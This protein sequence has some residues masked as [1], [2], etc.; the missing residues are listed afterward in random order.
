[1]RRL[2]SVLL[3]RIGFALLDVALDVGAPGWVG[4]NFRRPESVPDRDVR[5]DYVCQ[6]D[7]FRALQRAVV[8]A[9]QALILGIRCRNEGSLAAPT[10][11]PIVFRDATGHNP[12]WSSET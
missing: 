6:V 8:D 11:D 9:P 10:A 7:V 12:C 4:V 3:I 2:E 5:R 1:M